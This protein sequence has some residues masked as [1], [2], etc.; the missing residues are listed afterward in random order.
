MKRI[1]I[2]HGTPLITGASVDTLMTIEGGDCRLYTG[3]VPNDADIGH[4][5]GDRYQLIVPA[6][7]NVYAT[8]ACPCCYAIMSDF[9]GSG[10]QSIA[11]KPFSMT[12]GDSGDWGG[13][14]DGDIAYP[15]FNPPVG[16]I[17]NQPAPGHDLHALYPDTTDGRLTAV[18]QGDIR[19]LVS[20]LNVR[21]DSQ[22][23]QSV[24]AEIFGG[25][26]VIA[27]DPPINMLDITRTYSVAFY[28]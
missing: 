3:S 24:S 18:F 22:D 28:Q 23:Y 20:G 21:V 16:S 19:S 14:S 25:N 2:G 15:P 8:T 12:A 5:V 9:G 1:E 7:V 13:Y 4:L 17:T 27:F 10:V 6:G 26:T 11:W